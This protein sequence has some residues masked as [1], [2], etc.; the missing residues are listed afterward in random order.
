MAAIQANAFSAVAEKWW[1]WRG[2][3]TPVPPELAPEASTERAAF[4]G[5]DAAASAATSA[6][7]RLPALEKEFVQEFYNAAAAQW[8]GSR[9]LAWPCVRRFVASLPKHA[10]VCDAGCGDGKN[11]LLGPTCGGGPAGA[12]CGRGGALDLESEPRDKEDGMTLV[13]EASGTAAAAATG[14]SGWAIGAD[15]SLELARIS[16][17]L[18]YE[19]LAADALC[20]PFRDSS[21]GGCLSIAVLHHISSLARRALLVR[22]CGRV[23]AVGGRALVCAWARE[24]RGTAP[25]G[26]A[27]VHC[28]SFGAADVMVPWTGGGRRTQFPTAAATPAADLV[29]KNTGEPEAKGTHAEGQRTAK[30]SPSAG[31]SLGD[32]RR[33]CHLFEAG[34]V[35]ALVAV[36][37]E[38]R[39]TAAGPW[40]RVEEDFYAEGH[41]C[42]VFTKIA[43]HR[44]FA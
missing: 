28:H 26:A 1:G 40:L 10:L 23:L 13:E 41:W 29:V 6:A 21:F 44:V 22:E 33:Y 11:L 42:L 20:L 18:G 34:E 16:G 38:E 19:A 43:D 7:R 24:Q 37:N 15:N 8:Q 5:G 2:G 3:A 31:A 17:A 36:L 27:G 39:G 30:A 14:G 25:G 9:Q 4:V 12:P 35:A 32:L